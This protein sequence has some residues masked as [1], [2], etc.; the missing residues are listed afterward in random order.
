MRD[1]VIA[2][3]IFA[4]AVTLVLFVQ[5]Q[6]LP[7]KPP[8]EILLDRNRDELIV[9][10][11]FLK[12]ELIHQSMVESFLEK[13]E[14]RAKE[15]KGLADL[16]AL[17]LSL[18]GQQ[19]R[20]KALLE[21]LGESSKRQILEFSLGFSEDLPL[22]WE[23][24]Y[25]DGWF[26]AKIASL[27]YKREHDDTR[28]AE[29]LVSIREYE[30]VTHRFARI[31]TVFQFLGFL[32]FF[33]LIG[34]IFSRRYYRMVG[35]PFFQLEPLYL[36]L[37]RF[38]RFCGLFLIGFVLTGSIAGWLFGGVRNLW[39]MVL[40]Y[41]MFVVVSLYLM[42]RSFFIAEQNDV[43]K[44]LDLDD[45]KMRFSYLWQILRSFAILVALCLGALTLSQWVGWPVDRFQLNTFY[46]NVLDEPLTAGVFFTLACI[47][48]PI[49]EEVFFRGMIQRALLGFG[50]PIVAIL[51]STLLF[52]FIHPMAQ[53]PTTF[54]IGLGLGL[55]YQ[56]TGNLLICIWTHAAWNGMVLLLL[57]WGVFL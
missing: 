14:E 21:I 42:R 44:T 24:Q 25:E 8:E 13:A 33:F 40:G 53:W 7:P 6:N 23:D 34:M 48:A 1:L 55:V 37:P 26:K 5:I 19:D 27:I 47:F 20:A 43:L 4:F 50:K 45:L 38:L 30:N 39:A 11:L 51:G 36:P 29:S 9:S 41:L 32:G 52:G 15:R 18:E 46:Q 22:D 57:S 35:K 10:Y 3:S 17:L 28:Y 49:F 16:V 56:R 12:S 54:A 2:A 31:N